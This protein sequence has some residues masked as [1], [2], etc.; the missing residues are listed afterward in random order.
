MVRSF[1]W[2]T[3]QGEQESVL[4]F[5]L[6]SVTSRSQCCQN[7]P[8]HLQLWKHFRTQRAGIERLLIVKRSWYQWTEVI[9]ILME[10]WV[11]VEK[12]ESALA[13]RMTF[14]LCYRSLMPAAMLELNMALE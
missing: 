4:T 14:G 11:N 2:N 9:N 13:P 6:T 1:I 12:P 8:G 5:P 3:Y 10:S 7:C